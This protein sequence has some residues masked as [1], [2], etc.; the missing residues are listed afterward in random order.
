MAADLSKLDLIV[1]QI[2]G[3]QIETDLVLLAAVGIDGDGVKHPLGVLE[4]AS[5]NAAVAQALLDNLIER[6]LD[7][8][9]CRLFIIDG[10]KA[11]RKAIRKTFGKHTPVQRCQIHKGRNIRRPSQ[12]PHAS[13]RQTLPSL[14]DREVLR[15]FAL[16][17][18][19]RTTDAL[20]LIMARVLIRP[21]RHSWLEDIRSGSSATAH[22]E[23]GSAHARSAGAGGQRLSR[24]AAGG[25]LLAR[26]VVAPAPLRGLIR[27]NPVSGG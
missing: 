4:G 27:R 16:N 19:W 18:V 21:L 17:V 23:F 10:A 7:P 11:L 14:K 13:V 12:A 5:D 25:H 20:S 6:G 24:R 26:H 3:I 22:L 1:I 15:A 2:D 8:K 9:I